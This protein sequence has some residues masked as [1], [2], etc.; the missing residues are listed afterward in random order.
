MKRAALALLG[1]A[2]F[3]AVLGWATLAQRGATCEVCVRS[4]GGGTHCVETSAPTRAE[5]REG[6]LRTACGTVEGDL[7]GDLAC[8]RTPPAKVACRE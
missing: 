5:A 7:T 6:A 3:V 2:A 8:L 1:V 4:G